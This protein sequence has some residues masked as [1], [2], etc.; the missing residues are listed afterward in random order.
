MGDGSLRRPIASCG[1]R[2]LALWVDA[3]NDLLILKDVV[4][5]AEGDRSK[6]EIPG[7]WW[8]VARRVFRPV[9]NGEVGRR[10]T[11]LGVT[12]ELVGG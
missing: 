3:D 10:N 4:A 1:R 6:V 9:D 2:Q 12:L 5:E 8:V 7:R 11:V